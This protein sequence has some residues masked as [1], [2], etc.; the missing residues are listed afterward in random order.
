MT[1]FDSESLLGKLGAVR[2]AMSVSR[3]F[4]ESYRVDDV[5]VIPV[6]LVRGGGGGGTGPGTDAQPD[7]EPGR[8]GGGLGFGI[9]V[10]PVG[11]VVVKGGDV[12]WQPTVDVNRA[13]LGGQLLALAAILVIRRLVARS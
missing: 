8:S 5:T 9:N 3:A 7:D 13:I 6:A 10:R 11:V 4:G 1:R 2:D 12:R